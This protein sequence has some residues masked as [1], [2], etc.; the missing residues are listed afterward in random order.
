MQGF[1]CSVIVGK[2]CKNSELLLLLCEFGRS[3]LLLPLFFFLMFFLPCNAGLVLL[4]RI[5]LFFI[6]IELNE[7][8]KTGIWDIVLVGN[9]L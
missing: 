8:V 7:F 9:L 2:P 5:L 4:G 6:L 1:L 3:A